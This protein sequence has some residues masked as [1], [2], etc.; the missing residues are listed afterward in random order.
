MPTSEAIAIDDF[1][2]VHWVWQPG[3]SCTYGQGE[4]IEKLAQLHSLCC[5]ITD[6]PT[7]RAGKTLD[8]I[9]SNISGKIA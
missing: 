9:W 6:E 1:D 7:Q 5:L 4:G 3:A 8:L 2:S